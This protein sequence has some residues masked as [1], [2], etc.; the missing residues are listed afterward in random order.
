M[1]EL[2]MKSSDDSVIFTNWLSMR[3]DKINTKNWIYSGVYNCSFLSMYK[4][5]NQYNWTD[6][7]LHLCV[8]RYA[9]YILIYC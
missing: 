9:S 5:Q 8:F 2:T 6:C 3:V 7:V 4:L 1:K